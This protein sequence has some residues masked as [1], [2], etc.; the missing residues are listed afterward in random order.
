M[1]LKTVM[2]ISAVTMQLLFHA[3]AFASEE[4]N[5]KVD[6]AFTV[7]KT[8]V[9]IPE[10]SVPPVLLNDA[11]GI[12]IV[13][14]L[15]KIGFIVGGRYGSGVLLVRGK[16]GE[17]SNPVFV[18]IAGGSIGW[19]FGAA[20]SDIILV[21]KSERSIDGIKKGKFTLGG[22][23]S[24]AA[25][26]VGRDL[27]AATDVRL[28]S[29]VYS[30]SRSRGLFVGISLEGAAMQI[31]W[32]ANASFYGKKGVSADDV[33]TGRVGTEYAGAGSLRKMLAKYATLPR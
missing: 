15:L 26:P 24:I 4:E 14:R 16:G 33:I 21:F 2:I 23:A 31:D 7:L 1:W 25:G 20:S 5:E 28:E 8:I 12:A 18:S 11:Y 27:A 9:D 29:E 10:E 32:D 13:P 17:W 19:Q 6:D 22:N 30:Y 3:P